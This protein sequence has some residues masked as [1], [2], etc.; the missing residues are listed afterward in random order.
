MS[1]SYR[2]LREGMPEPKGL[3]AGRFV[4][5]PRK[6]KAWVQALPRANAQATVHELAQA[7]DNFAGW[8]ATQKT[9]LEEDRNRLAAILV[10]RG[11]R[12]RAPGENRSS[13]RQK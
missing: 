11:Q 3:G 6:V 13:P 1:H 4:A 9:I 2:L 7:L 8:V 10:S 5:E 12:R